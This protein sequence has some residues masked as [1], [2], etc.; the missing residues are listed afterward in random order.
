MSRRRL[1]GPGSSR[2][3]PD[4]SL[5]GAVLPRTALPVFGGHPRHLEAH[6]QRLEAG[7]VAL[8]QPVAWLQGILGELRDWLVFS[9]QG[10]DSALRLVLDPGEGFLSARIES[11][12]QVPQS[13]RLVLIMHPLWNRQTDPTV[14]HKGLAGPWELQVLATARG[15][16][17]DD[18]L[19]QWPDGSLAET[20]IAS[21]GVETDGV[22][23]V[24]PL[25][26]RVA[27]LT[28]RLELPDWARFRGLRIETKA[29][30]LLS[31]RRGQIWCMN[32]LRGIWPATLL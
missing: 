29:M 18:A 27:S 22:L 14:I 7:A 30:P 26:G 32:A 9:T 28:E 15:L 8:G 19:L 23:M 2:L 13:Y 6:F 17:A 20:A 12:P 5:G 3:S 1:F 31:A 24:P 16:G 21:V 10:G 25:Q 4:S 11:L